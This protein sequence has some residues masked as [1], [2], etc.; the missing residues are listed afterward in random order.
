MRT[1]RLLV[2]K[3]VTVLLL[4]LWVVVGCVWG[5]QIAIMGNMWLNKLVT[6]LPG[7]EEESG[8]EKFPE[9]SLRT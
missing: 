9:F 8:R 1:F 5:S 2:A 7:S 6:S 3:E 4:L